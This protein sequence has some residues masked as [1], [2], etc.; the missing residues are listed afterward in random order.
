M[1]S[2]DMNYRVLL[3]L[4]FGFTENELF[5]LLEEKL[6]LIKV[7]YTFNEI[8]RMHWLRLKSNEMSEFN[9]K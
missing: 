7:G 4:D 9:G 6:S 8:F 5:E 1:E 3:K 2:K